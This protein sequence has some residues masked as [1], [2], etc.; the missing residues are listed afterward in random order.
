MFSQKCANEAR[1]KHSHVFINKQH[2]FLNIFYCR[3]KYI[4]LFFCAVSPNLLSFG[5]R[6]YSTT[7]QP[8]KSFLWRYWTFISFF[9][10]LT[11]ITFCRYLSIVSSIFRVC[12]YL[13]VTYFDQLLLDAHKVHVVYLDQLLGTAHWYT[14]YQIMIYPLQNFD[15]LNKQW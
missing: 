14:L 3:Q 12:R 11:F 7:T 5:N 8:N 4:L 13:K 1:W 15:I 6:F 2:K 9:Y 10:V